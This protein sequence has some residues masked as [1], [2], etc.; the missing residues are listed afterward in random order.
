MKNLT[1]IEWRATDAHRRGQL[2]KTPPGESVSVIVRR[3]Q[4]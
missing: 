2:N 1:Q 4:C 3:W